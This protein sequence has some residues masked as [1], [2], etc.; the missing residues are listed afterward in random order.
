MIDADE[1]DE[2]LKEAIKDQFKS[3]LFLTAKYLL[4]YKDITWHTHGDMIRALESDSKR[5]MILMPRGT[6][7]SSLASV[8]YPI[9]LLMRD[10]N[11]RIMLD[12]EVFT[13]AAKMV[14]EIRGH[15]ESQKFIDLFG[16]WIG[17]IWTD[18]EIT[19]STRTKNLKDPSIAAGAIETTR[20]GRHV[21]AIIC[22]DL[23][24][25][26]N[27]Q[28]P[29]ACKKVIDHFKMLTPILEPVGLSKIVVVGT[30]YSAADLYQ[31]I[32]DELA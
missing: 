7:K 5:V 27:S 26:N 16:D 8:A 32:K 12:G 23:H 13:N 6:F 14:I 25:E 31:H 17:P 9:W 4:G 11:L 10:P 22:D 28:T 21:D 2:A 19:I 15:L 20:T 29:E 3:S 18:K 30:R 24:S 1:Y